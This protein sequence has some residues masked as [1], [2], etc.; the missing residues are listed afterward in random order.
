MQG[1]SNP[2]RRQMGVLYG[3]MGILVED[4]EDDL[5]QPGTQAI[6]I[7]GLSGIIAGGFFFFARIEPRKGAP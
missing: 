1:Y 6:L 4:L 7:A 3:K 2:Q 5:K